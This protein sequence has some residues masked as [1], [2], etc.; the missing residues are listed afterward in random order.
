[1]YINSGDDDD[2]QIEAEAARFYS[3]LR[4]N[5]QPAEL[6]IVN[7]THNWAVWEST[8]PDAL[9]YVFRYSARPMLPADERRPARQP[10]SGKE[11]AP[12]SR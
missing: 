9:R 3:L 12:I 7:G 11:A 4:K 6:R 2:F 8:L 10:R 5:K 1:M